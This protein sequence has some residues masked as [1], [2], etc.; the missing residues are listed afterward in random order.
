MGTKEIFSRSQWEK[1]K[2]FLG[3]PLEFSIINIFLPQ[4]TRSFAK[5]F[6]K[7]IGRFK[8]Q[9]FVGVS[10]GIHELKKI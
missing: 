10:K 7:K 6:P 4:R 1:L 2:L 8:G 5:I 3:E 9:K